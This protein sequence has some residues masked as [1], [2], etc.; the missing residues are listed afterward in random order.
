VSLVQSDTSFILDVN[1]SDADHLDIN[2]LNEALAGLAEQAPLL[3]GLGLALDQSE[4]R[5]RHLLD[6]LG[7]L[8]MQIEVNTKANLQL[9]D[10]FNQQ[11]DNQQLIQKSLDSLQSNV[12]HLT[13]NQTALVDS[14]SLTNQTIKTQQQ[15]LSSLLQ[16][17]NQQM[18]MQL[19][20]QQAL[21]QKQTNL[22]E[23]LARHQQATLQTS[24]QQMANEVTERLR[25]IYNLWQEQAV[26]QDQ[27]ANLRQ[28][29]LDATV[30]A[31]QEYRE[32]Q[33][34][35][36]TQAQQSALQ[37]IVEH[38]DQTYRHLGEHLQQ[39]E[40]LFQKL[41]DGQDSTESGREQFN[42][43]LLQSIESINADSQGRVELGT[44]LKILI[45]ELQARQE[46]MHQALSLALAVEK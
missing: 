18:A 23:E 39:L 11:A 7:Q 31:D 27:I 4:R 25:A 45:S 29:K 37:T 24:H 19:W 6:G 22:Q 32:R 28:Q 35:Q 13:A 46:Q 10:L 38:A 26:Q 44:Q 16:E 40:H 5:V 34:Q 9:I 17:Q 3:Q 20:S 30:Q 43:L 14:V 33:I 41:V 2:P 15:T 8:F 21:W 36:F 42:R 12:E 1:E